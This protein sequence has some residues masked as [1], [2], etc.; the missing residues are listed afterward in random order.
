M[1]RYI[2]FDVETPN[3]YNN[4]MSA[5]GIAVIEQGEITEEFFSYVNPETR[6]DTFNTQLTGIDE[7]T[8]KDAPTFPQLWRRIEPLMSSGILAAHNAVFDM[9]VLKHCLRDYGIPWKATAKYCCTVQMGRRLVPGMSHSLNVMCDHYG[10]HLNHHQAD[11]DSRA[12][13]EIL[14]RYFAAGAQ[15]RDFIRTYRLI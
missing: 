11:S 13:A 6:F 7:N 2:A 3:R 8:V 4:R 9:G 10:I 14:L 1:Y 15:E 5:I 12:C